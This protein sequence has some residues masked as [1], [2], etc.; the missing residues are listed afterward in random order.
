[1]RS[2][3]QSYCI[4]ISLEIIPCLTWY[5]LRLI[6]PNKITALKL[7][8]RCCL[9]QEDPSRAEAFRDYAARRK[10]S[11]WTHFLNMLNRPDHFI[12]NQVI[13]VPSPSRTFH[14]R[15]CLI[16][17][18]IVCV[19]LLSILHCECSVLLLSPDCSHHHEDRLLAGRLPPPTNG[20]LRPH[21][22]PQLA[23]RTA[24]AI[25]V[26]HFAQLLYLY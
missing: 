26:A 2:E 19:D 13:T 3:Q 5:A 22:L 6:A 12:V 15:G 18:N 14:A 20:R 10:E 8:S 23:L 25:R 24:Q 11:V 17:F 1:M 7:S 4:V 9:L 16:N 21:L